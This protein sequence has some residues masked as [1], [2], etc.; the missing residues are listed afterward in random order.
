MDNLK[1]LYIAEIF[2]AQ[3]L[4][5]PSLHLSY[6]LLLPYFVLSRTMFPERGAKG[7]ERLIFW[8]LHAIFSPC[9]PWSQSQ[10][11]SMHPVAKFSF[12]YDNLH[13]VCVVK[14]CGFQPRMVGEYFWPEAAGDTETSRFVPESR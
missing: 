1:Y 3:F 10:P 9:V 12:L 6:R 2:H 8:L 4:F 13:R 11:L 7:G 5:T 14:F